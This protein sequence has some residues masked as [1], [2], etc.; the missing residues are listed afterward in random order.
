M[1]TAKERV[2]AAEE[3]V[4]VAEELAKVAEE[5][6]KVAKEQA[7]AVEEIRNKLSVKVIELIKR[8][9]DLEVRLGIAENS[10]GM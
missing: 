7:D 5:R 3:R 8:T 10:T 9:S 2:D 4:K 6:A 1:K